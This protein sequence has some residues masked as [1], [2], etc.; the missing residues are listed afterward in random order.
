MAS[1]LFPH[2]GQLCPVGLAR[3]VGRKTLIHLLSHYF[4]GETEKFIEIHDITLHT[5]QILE[6]IYDRH[7]HSL[8]QL[9]ILLS[10]SLNAEPLETYVEISR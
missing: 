6:I 9:L 5:I 7:A 1:T 4:A 2:R 8:L 10:T 3:E